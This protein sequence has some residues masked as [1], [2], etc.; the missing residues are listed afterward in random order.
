MVE[1]V[2]RGLLGDHERVYALQDVD[3]LLAGLVLRLI[4]DRDRHPA[5]VAEIQVAK[6]DHEHER[7]DEAEE[8]GRSITHVAAE[9]QPEETDGL[10]HGSR[11]S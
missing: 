9:Q 3:E 2:V 10:S 5:E 1:R 8:E 6:D 4:V 7:D 11:S